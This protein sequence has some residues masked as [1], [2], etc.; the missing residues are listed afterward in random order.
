MTLYNTALVHRAERG[1][2]R[3]EQRELDE[4]MGELASAVSDLRRAMTDLF[5]A[6]GRPPASVA[7]AARRIFAPQ[8]RPR[9]EVDHAVHAHPCH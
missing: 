3:D 7:R 5:R 2:S 4:N 8:V 1:L 6:F 9:S